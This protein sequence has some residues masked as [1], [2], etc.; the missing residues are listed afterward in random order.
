MRLKRRREKGGIEKKG[1]K[2]K[3]LA[4]S[5]G[6]GHVPAAG[7]QQTENMSTGHRLQ[8]LYRF[9]PAE[10]L[11]AFTP[12]LFPESTINFSTPACPCPPA[13]PTVYTSS[14]TSKKIVLTSIQTYEHQ[15]MET[16]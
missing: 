3:E 2:E 12:C 14:K 10:K 11:S 7:Q 4:C 5:P 15:S 16:T 6:L 9:L 8:H 13:H 1:W